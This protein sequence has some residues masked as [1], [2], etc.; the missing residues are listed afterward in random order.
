MS[1]EF[2]VQR[3]G[4]LEF[5]LAEYFLEMWWIVIW[6]WIYQ[7][8]LLAEIPKTICLNVEKPNLYQFRPLLGNVKEK[9]SVD[10]E[11]KIWK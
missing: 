4:L 1:I 7:R 9:R 11:P 6:R 2:N 10:G 8:E 3:T 5:S